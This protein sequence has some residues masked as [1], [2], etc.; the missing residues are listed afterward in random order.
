MTEHSARKLGQDIPRVLMERDTRPMHEML[1]A[2]VLADGG[3]A[4][5]AGTDSETRRESCVKAGRP[6][7]ARRVDHDPVGLHSSCEIEDRL[8]IGAMNGGGMPGAGEPKYCPRHL[9]RLLPRD[10]GEH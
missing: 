10:S 2:N 5:E 9:D 1:R 7:T 6:L 3:A 8:R 4:E